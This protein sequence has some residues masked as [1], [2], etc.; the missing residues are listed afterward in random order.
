MNII[1]MLNWE[2]KNYDKKKIVIVVFNVYS[3]CCDNRTPYEKCSDIDLGNFETIEEAQQFQKDC[4]DFHLNNNN[5]NN[6]W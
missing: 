4:R 2:E 6:D 5:N 3:K 1:K